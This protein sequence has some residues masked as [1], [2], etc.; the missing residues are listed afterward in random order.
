MQDLGDTP[1]KATSNLSTSGQV[2]TES[3]C[4]KRE[5]NKAHGQ[6]SSDSN[7]PDAKREC[8]GAEYHTFI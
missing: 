4:P 5:K 1:Q 7:L 2:D 3:S 6:K 8:L